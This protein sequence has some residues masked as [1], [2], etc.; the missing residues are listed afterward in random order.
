MAKLAFSNRQSTR[1]LDVR[2]LRQITLS[3]LKEL[4]RVDDWDLTFY[5]VNSRRIAELNESHLG[6][7]GATDVI[8]FGYNDPDTPWQI[9]GE[10]FIC[11]EV[12]V[13]QAQE[14]RTRWQAEVVRY[15]VH[16][17][18]H[19]CGYDDLR[20]ADRRKMKQVENRLVA[21]L[22]RQFKLTTLGGQ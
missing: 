2:L 11:I 7:E 1:P 14:F 8:T 4:P 17:I 10:I 20:P 13:A 5:F 12:A 15:V 9:A 6:H 22:S 18:L 21:R 16:S 3:V 19:L